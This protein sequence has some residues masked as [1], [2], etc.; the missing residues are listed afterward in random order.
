MRL[1]G[2][3]CGWIAYPFRHE[4]PSNSIS[5]F[6]HP[7]R[8]PSRN[9]RV[10]PQPLLQTSNQILQLTRALEINILLTL[11]R[12]SH[13]LHQ[14]LHLLRIPQQIVRRPTQ[15]RRRRLAPRKHK[16]PRIALHLGLAEPVLGVVVFEDVGQEVLAVGV[17]TFGDAALG[18]GIP[19]FVVL[20]ALFV[21]GGGDA[22]QEDGEDPVE[23]LGGVYGGIGLEGD[24]HGADPG[25]EFSLFETAEGFAEGEVAVA[26]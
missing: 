10:N 17:E 25:V 21:D 20:G 4:F 23:L 11:K 16:Q 7:P 3:E 13:L 19:E 12:P 2:R 6:R 26:S 15:Q 8:Q 18:F 14:L 22:A 1:D 24:E 9:R 5:P